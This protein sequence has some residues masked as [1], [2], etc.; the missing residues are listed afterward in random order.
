MR[1]EEKLPSITSR[2]ATCGWGAL[3]IYDGRHVCMHAGVAILIW[4]GTDDA[5]GGSGGGAVHHRDRHPHGHDFD[6]VHEVHAMV[7]S[8]FHRASPRASCPHSPLP[9]SN[10]HHGQ[11]ERASRKGIESSRHRIKE[12]AS[13]CEIRRKCGFKRFQNSHA[14]AFP[15]ALRNVSPR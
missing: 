1:F 13:A 8:F 15:G 4:V 7:R 9:G 6:R 5:A 10:V 2:W 14:S 3:T 12:T 11:R